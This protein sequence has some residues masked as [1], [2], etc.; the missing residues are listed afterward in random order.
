[1]APSPN[2]AFRWLKANEWAL[3]FSILAVIAGTAILDSNHS[4]VK[5]PNDALRDNIRRIAPIGMMALGATVVII[6]GGIDLSAGSMAALS[7]TICACVML[8]L[9]GDKLSSGQ[10]VGPAIIAC[11][12]ACSLFASLVIGTMHTWM[13]T[14]LRL[15]PFIVTLGSLVGLRSL[16]QALCVYV[17]S[18]VKNS[19]SIDLPFNDPFFDLLK[20][21]VLISLSLMLCLALSIGFILS[22]TVLGRHLHALGGNEQASL[23]CGV[24]TENVKWFAYVV[25]AFCSALAGIFFIAE[26]G[27]KPTITA[28]GYELTAIAASVVGGCSLQGGIGTVPGTILG[29]I[30]LRAVVDA[31]ARIIKTSSSVYEGMIIGTIVV[32]AVTITQLRQIRQ[33]GRQLF[34]G[35]LGKLAIPCLM[36]MCGLVGLIT[37]GPTAGIGGLLLAGTVIAGICLSER[38]S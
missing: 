1:M 36:L 18:K 10:T 14:S 22:R 38:T 34:P 37:A 23:L 3:V 29:A 25:S 13:I 17:T 9:A 16:A 26:G 11:G 19:R 21:Q 20:D 7:G 32:I 27:A 30:F 6:A 2:I 24:R 8:A 5:A 28:N 4:Y 12:V 31:V 33:S 15:P 35:M